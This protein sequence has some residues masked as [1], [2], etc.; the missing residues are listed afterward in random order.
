MDDCEA[1]VERAKAAGGTLVFGPNDIPNAGRAA[2]ISDPAG[3]IFVAM[4]PTETS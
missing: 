1:A 3:A 4:Q 2:I